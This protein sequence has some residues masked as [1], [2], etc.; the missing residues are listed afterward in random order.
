VEQLF[1]RLN[2]C[3]EKELA[4]VGEIHAV[5]MAQQAALLESDLAGL[6]K[7]LAQL[8]DLERDLR[9]IE[10]ERWLLSGKLAEAQGLA[11][12][13]PLGQIAAVCPDPRRSQLETTG[14][15]LRRA[16]E[17]VKA[18]GKANRLLI[19]N[20]QRFNQCLLRVLS[21]AG[22][23]YSEN[24]RVALTGNDPKLVNKEV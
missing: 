17:A 23:T 7:S 9:R 15:E 10:E 6:E 21:G 1:E 8:I 20:A 24:G 16:L 5:V 22:Q 13:A 12:D 11:P 2:A 14:R 3:L 4:L 18:A 19:V